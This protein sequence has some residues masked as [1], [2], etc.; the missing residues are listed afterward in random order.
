MK[1]SVTD[2]EREYKGGPFACEFKMKGAPETEDVV[3][4]P[5]KQ[6]QGKKAQVNGRQ[7]APS[8]A[9]PKIREIRRE[10]WQDPLYQ[11]TEYSAVKIINNDETDG[12]D[13]F[14]NIDNKFLI[15]ELH[16]AKDDEKALVKHWFIYGV[17]LA[18]LGM[19]GELQR[20]QKEKEVNDEQ[21]N[22]PE[23]DLETISQ[24]CA[25]VARVVVP[26]I[27]AL[28]KGPVAS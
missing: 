25:G 9:M 19:L 10:Q 12:Y 26:I 24:L 20:H 13:F 11:F 6:S 14:V 17:V 21:D 15:N 3:V 28:Y 23:L 2:I 27:R 5:G 16:R 1:V 8:L 4:P 7:T 22:G 18:G